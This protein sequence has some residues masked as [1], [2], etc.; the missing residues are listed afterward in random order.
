M[1]DSLHNVSLIKIAAFSVFAFILSLLAL[2]IIEPFFPNN[3]QNFLKFLSELGIVLAVSLFTVRHLDRKKISLKSIFGETSV[4]KKMLLF[5]SLLTIGKLIL[6]F[7]FAGLVLR[8]FITRPEISSFALSFMVDA[9]P[10]E[11]STWLIISAV[12]LAPITEEFIFRGLILNKWAEKSS[13]TRALIISSLL[14]GVLH[15]G[16][17]IIPQF[18]GG[19]LYGIVYIKTKKLIYPILMHV[20]NNLIAVSLLLFP[21]TESNDVFSVPQLIEE[22]TPVLNISSLVFVIA[23]PIFI[24]IVYKYSRNLNDEVAPFAFNTRN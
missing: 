5:S 22:M 14:F 18:I 24:F 15:F 21:T 9:S 12:I 23:L 10:T 16:S 6:Y 3:S 19:L 4:S 8:I 20:I 13:N 17:F 2:F 1:D 11:S 7:S